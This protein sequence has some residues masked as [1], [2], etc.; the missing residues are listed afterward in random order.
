ME[1]NLTVLTLKKSLAAKGRFVRATRPTLS[2]FTSL[3]IRTSAKIM[4]FRNVAQTH[5]QDTNG[6]VADVALTIPF[7]GLVEL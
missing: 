4:K 7:G 1:I 3:K 6:T 2:Q 5:Y